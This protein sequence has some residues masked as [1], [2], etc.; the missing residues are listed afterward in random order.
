MAKQKR[1]G[2]K[3][4]YRKDPIS[5]KKRPINIRYVNGR[6]VERHWAN[7]CKKPKNKL[8]TLNAADVDS[9]VKSM[10][11]DPKDPDPILLNEFYSRDHHDVFDRD[12]RKDATAA[13]LKLDEDHR[14]KKLDDLKSYKDKLEKRQKISNNLNEKRRI[15]NELYAVKYS[16]RRAE[17]LSEKYHDLLQVP[18]KYPKSYSKT[19]PK[20]VQESLYE[21]QKNDREWGGGVN[22]EIP[23]DK[24]PAKIEVREGSKVACKTDSLSDINVHTHPSRNSK[25]LENWG[26]NEV[27]LAQQ[28]IDRL[29]EKLKSEKSKEKIKELKDSLKSPYNY[30]PSSKDI[31]GVQEDEFDRSHVVISDKGA[32]IMTKPDYNV[33]NPDLEKDLKNLHVDSMKVATWKTE[34]DDK[35]INSLKEAEQKVK[36]YHNE[37]ITAEK[38]ALTQHKIQSEFYPKEEK[39]QV[40]TQDSQNRMKKRKDERKFYTEE[41]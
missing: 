24:N 22:L 19:L 12:T 3:K 25:T 1:N 27:T 34:L 23:Q 4:T 29:N 37:V 40:L 28:N 20:D 18:R 13:F 6:E 11:F 32:F 16:I 30:L 36:Q 2:W 26:P 38:S 41:K 5:G 14:D 17:Y 39:I 33:G 35:P 8:Q 10:G 21:L 9:E 31:Q 7:E 15:S